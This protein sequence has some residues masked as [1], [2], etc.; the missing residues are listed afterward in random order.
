[1]TSCSATITYKEKEY[2]ISVTRYWVYTDPKGL[3]SKSIFSL[4]VDGFFRGRIARNERGLW[5]PL[6][7]YKASH[8]PFYQLVGEVIEQELGE[9]V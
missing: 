4:V 7:P 2:H 6:D 5:E 8:Q 9:Y 1:M 3:Q